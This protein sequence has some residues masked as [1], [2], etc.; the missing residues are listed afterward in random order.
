MAKKGH[1]QGCRDPVLEILAPL[2]VNLVKLCAEDVECAAAG[3]LEFAMNQL[4]S[5]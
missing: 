1:I 4:R 3:W 2:A 5:P